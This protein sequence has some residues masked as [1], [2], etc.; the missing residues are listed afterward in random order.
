MDRRQSLGQRGT[1]P[2]DL[3]GRQRGD[4]PQ[5]RPWDVGRRHPRLGR[6]RVGVHHLRGVETAHLASRLDLAREPHPEL[7]AR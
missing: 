3:L 4:I 2:G 1:E 6:L 7:R 5:G